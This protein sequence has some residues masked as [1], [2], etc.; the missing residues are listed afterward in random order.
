MAG[1]RRIGEGDAGRKLVVVPVHCQRSATGLRPPRSP[2]NYVFSTGSRLRKDAII[3]TRFV[4]RKRAHGETTWPRSLSS[5][6][7][8]ESERGLLH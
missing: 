4:K 5:S 1:A 6:I 2:E 7:I 8:R 3:E